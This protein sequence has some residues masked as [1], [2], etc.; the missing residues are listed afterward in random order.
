VV[1][2][3]VEGKRLVEFAIGYGGEPKSGNAGLAEK[4]CER[5]LVSAAIDEDDFEI[6]AGEFGYIVL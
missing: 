1:R 6:R 5:V 4:S 3:E 2:S